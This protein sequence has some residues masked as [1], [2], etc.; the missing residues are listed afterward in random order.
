[1]PAAAIQLRVRFMLLTPEVIVCPRHRL[2][3]IF[4]SY[5]FEKIIKMRLNRIFAD[6]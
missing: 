3:A 1:M 4:N 2:R 6:K 5:L